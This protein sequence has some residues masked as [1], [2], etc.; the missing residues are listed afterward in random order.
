MSSI[1]NSAQK[2]VFI[3]YSTKDQ[4]AKDYI[5]KVFD[6]EGITYFLDEVSLELG[7]DI[8][9]SLEDNLDRTNFTVLLVSKNSLFSTWV[10]LESIHRLRQQEYTKI[11]TFLPVLID[12][13]VMDLEF[14][15]EMIN[16]YKN[17]HDELEALREKAKTA[18]LP[19]KV[20]NDEIERIDQIIPQVG[21][22]VQRIKNGLS[23]N[24]VNESRKEVDLAKLISTIKARQRETKTINSIANKKAAT[25]KNVW[26]IGGGVLVF[27]LILFIVMSG[28]NN[29][30]SNSESSDNA[31]EEKSDTLAKEQ[32]TENQNP[33]TIAPIIIGD[34]YQIENKAFSGYSLDVSGSSLESGVQVFLYTTHQANNQKFI[35]GDGGNGYI[36]LE[37]VNSKKVLEWRD[38]LQQSDYENNM[39]LKLFKLIPTD[40]GYFYLELVAKPNYVLTAIQE[41]RGDK[42]ITVGLEKLNNEPNQRFK[43]NAVE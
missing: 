21:E 4:A 35:L 33:N 14:P 32:V 28:G 15:I 30:N 41:E 9:R 26:L 40:D 25:P 22:I 27:L 17:K 6:Q 31:T 10:S 5:K 18:G 2:D 29:S 37:N 11:T 1:D 3:S 13:E 24:F 20:Y 19:T 38:R 36:I 34:T 12:L 7:E 43:F 23:A 8:E 42:A 16:Y 39:E